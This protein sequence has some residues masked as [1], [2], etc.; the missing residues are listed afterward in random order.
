M[1]VTGMFSESRAV[2]HL[3]SLW[4]EQALMSVAWCFSN[5]AFMSIWREEKKKNSSLHCHLL[6]RAV[7]YETLNWTKCEFILLLLHNLTKQDGV[8]STNTGSST[9]CQREMCKPTSVMLLEKM[10]THGG[11]Q[12]EPP[13]VKSIVKKT[14]LQQNSFIADF[15]ERWPIITLLALCNHPIYCPPTVQVLFSIE[16]RLAHAHF[17]ARCCAQGKEKCVFNR[18]VCNKTD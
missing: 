4:K 18:H 10:G 14:N 9:L 7:L 6:D 8:S 12:W 16:P 13:Q 3:I 5:W 11:K 17:V 1:G 15:I 2:A